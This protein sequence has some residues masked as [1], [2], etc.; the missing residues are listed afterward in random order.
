MPKLNSATTREQS[1]RRIMRLK[2]VEALTGFK[3]SSIYAF[4]KDG[5][6][7]KNVRIG[8]RAMG[9]DS[10]AIEDWLEARL[11]GKPFDADSRNEAV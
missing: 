5:T 11:N 6:F 4:M 7:P 1:P 8:P 9:W 10:W 2:E 3:H